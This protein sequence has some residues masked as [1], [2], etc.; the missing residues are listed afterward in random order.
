MV[1]MT[2]RRVCDDAR[3]ANTAQVDYYS[4]S[5]LVAAHALLLFVVLMNCLVDLT[6]L[7]SNKIFTSLLI[8]FVAKN[9]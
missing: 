4:M 3:F 8:T 6:P 9:V 1:S 2:A 7:G 5:C